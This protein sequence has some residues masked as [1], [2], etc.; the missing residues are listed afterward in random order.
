MLL[1]FTL[2]VTNHTVGGTPLRRHGVTQ[3]GVWL[4]VPKLHGVL[5]DER[6]M[7]KHSLI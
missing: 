2:S 3:Y 4:T 1:V 5:C 7:V 6:R